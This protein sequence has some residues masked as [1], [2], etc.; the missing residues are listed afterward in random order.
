MKVLLLEDHELPLVSGAALIRTGNLFD[1]PDKMGLAEL[2]GDVLRSGG[3][4]ASTGDQFDEDL[5]NIAASVES[6]IG[7]SS[8]TLS[9]SCLKEN[10]DEVLGIFHDV[11]TRPS[12][13]RTKSIW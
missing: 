8:G 11:L 9:F 12:S 7:E 10:T 5:E 6:Q 13:A 3:T 2:T 1:P 4:K